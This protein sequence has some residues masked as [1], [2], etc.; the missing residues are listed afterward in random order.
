MKISGMPLW[1]HVKIG[2]PS[3]QGSFSISVQVSPS[4]LTHGNIRDEMSSRKHSVS[5]IIFPFEI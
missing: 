5:V 2:A 4:H 1:T 3:Q